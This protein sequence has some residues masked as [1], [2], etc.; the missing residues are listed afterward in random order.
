[1]QGRKHN[2]QAVMS[3]LLAVLLA[4]ECAVCAFGAQPKQTLNGTVL[5][6]INTDYADM[7]HAKQFTTSADDRVEVPAAQARA[8]PAMPMWDELF[9]QPEPMTAEEAALADAEEGEIVSEQSALRPYHVGDRKIIRNV[10]MA[11]MADKVKDSIKVMLT[12][13]IRLTCM[14]VNDMITVWTQDGCGW[15]DA[16]LRELGE[17]MKK[18]IRT[19]EEMFGTAR[20]DTDKDGKFAI[21]VHE[22]PEELGGYFYP[23]DII[24]NFGRIGNVRIKYV[25]AGSWIG[26]SCDCFHV[27][28]N[29]PKDMI[30]STFVHE[31][32]H[33]IHTSYL[34]DGKNNK[35]YLQ[36]DELF[37]NEGFSLS[38]Q[39]IVGLPKLYLDS[40]VYGFNIMDPT[41]HAFLEWFTSSEIGMDKIFI[42]YGRA[43]FFFQYVR[44]RYAQLIGETEGDFPGKTVY[45]RILESRNRS[46]QDN[47]LGIIA[48]ILYPAAQYPSLADTDARCRQLIADFWQAVYE[49]KPSGVHGFGG[50]KWADALTV[51][52]RSAVMNGEEICGGMAAFY[53]IN[54]KKEGSVQIVEA[55]DGLRLTAIDAPSCSITFDPR[56]EG[57]EPQTYYSISGQYT[58]PRSETERL[59]RAGYSMTGWTSAPDAA[60]PEYK[61]GDTI[62]LTQNT[63][64]YGVWAEAVQL[65]AENTQH[66]AAA[67]GESVQMQLCPDL[68]GAYYIVSDKPY[69]ALV[70]NPS[71][72]LREALCSADTGVYLQGGETYNIFLDVDG[73]GA[74]RVEGEIRFCARETYYTLRYM[75]KEANTPWRTESYGTTYTASGCGEAAF[76]ED[77]I[78]WSKQP[79]ADTADYLPGDTI[80]LTADTTLYGV[81]KPWDAL[82]QDV[83]C[84]PEG[85][86]TQM[87]YARFTPPQT[88]SYGISF[89]DTAGYYPPFADVFDAD[90]NALFTWKDNGIKRTLYAD[91]TY[92]FKAGNTS[93]LCVQFDSASLRHKLYLKA[94]GKL[95][96]V[97]LNVDGAYTLPDYRPILLMEQSFRCWVDRETGEE[98]RPGDTVYMDRDR[99]LNA[100]GVEIDG[101]VKPKTVDDIS[102][103][104]RLLFFKAVPRS[105]VNN[106][107]AVAARIRIFGLKGIFNYSPV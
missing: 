82:T 90:G 22:M 38:A 28:W 47:T 79:Q 73:G 18:L 62:P 26:A 53:L 36:A 17:D 98:Y 71:L 45:R 58:I 76:G 75:L 77:F 55:D 19:D 39:M 3:L 52:M 88:A 9:E 5:A 30:R 84:T 81:F 54:D 23:A 25:S 60:A 91:R 6:A 7:E 102:P 69:T 92:Y 95:R 10:L 56:V 103:M 89:T 24:D 13:K 87:I 41:E 42:S 14:Y 12:R 61:A 27:N 2:I 20:I 46:N 107:R 101:Y 74:E 68:N 78:G 37:I 100:E 21:F 97:K 67:V 105:F 35:D 4:A 63:T 8:Y 15:T 104:L 49:K 94:G 1:M 43:L 57:F 85:R 72:N 44:T 80:T 65:R 31:Y 51:R 32:Q 48:D 29:C 11:G 16:A 40:Y 50:E 99:I 34:Y 93:S 66:Y 59:F 70:C 86:Q 83:P 33:Y 96:S 106:L 64:L